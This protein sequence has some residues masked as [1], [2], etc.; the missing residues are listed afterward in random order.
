MLGERYTQADHDLADKIG[1]FV[2]GSTD[3]D[4]VTKALQAE[5]AHISYSDVRAAL[6]K[7][8]SAMIDADPSIVHDTE[9][10]LATRGREQVMLSVKFAM[11]SITSE[12]GQDIGFKRQDTGRSR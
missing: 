10:K 4:T 2:T 7:Q 3:P 12:A 5:N 8:A 9:V 11:G 6:L 1:E